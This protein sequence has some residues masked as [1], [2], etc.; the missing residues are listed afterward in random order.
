MPNKTHTDKTSADAII[1]AFDYQYYYF[2]YKLFHLNEGESVGLEVNDDVH[3]VLNNNHQVLIQL[4]HSLLTTADGTPKN[5]TTLDSDLWK[6][7]FNWCEVI[8]DIN[9]KRDNLSNQKIFVNKT[10]FILVTNKASTT[11]NKFINSLAE[12]KN[13]SLSLND[14]KNKILDYSTI[15]ENLI[16]YK[17]KLLALDDS[18]LSIFF[19]NI[20]FNLDEIDLISKCKL[21]LQSKMIPEKNIDY[22]FKQLDSSIRENNYI[23]IKAGQQV[24]INFD[25]YYKL[26][27]KYYDL[28]R[29]TT[30]YI[31]KFDDTLPNDMTEQMFIKQLIEIEDIDITDIDTIIEFTKFKLQ[32][33]NNID[34]WLKEGDLTNE[35]LDVFKSNALT[36]WKNIFRPY[37]RGNMT[38]TNIAC[39]AL[40]TVDDTRKLKLK[41]STLDLDSQLSN[42]EFYY[43]SDKLELG[44]RKDWKEKY[45]E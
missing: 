17:N 38:E 7:I 23:S 41:I 1:V 34:S 40:L 19:N 25:E 6:T 22:L 2:L 14:F 13:Q 32:I 9:D 24:V 10:S 8:T 45:C 5:L 44:W 18:I 29:N 35:E 15:D 31:K 37:T 20:E 21:A 3:T 11:S 33:E 39:N 36:E 30:L 12:F 26:Y 28:A 42:G 16:K 4:K 27:R 43:L